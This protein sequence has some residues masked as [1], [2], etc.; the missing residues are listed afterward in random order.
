MKACE[1]LEIICF[2]YFCQVEK[3]ECENASFLWNRI[4]PYL[5]V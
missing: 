3:G 1:V 4:P 2:H 5:D